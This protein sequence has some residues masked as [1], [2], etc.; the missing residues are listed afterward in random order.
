MLTHPVQELRR[1][2]I[3]YN[4]DGVN[5]RQVFTNS[6]SWTV[7][8]QKTPLLYTIRPIKSK[9]LR[10]RPTWQALPLNLSLSSLRDDHDLARLLAPAATSTAQPA[11]SSQTQDTKTQ[12]PVL[13]ADECI[14]IPQSLPESSAFSTSALVSSPTTS[15]NESSISLPQT[16]SIPPHS[17]THEDWTF[18]TTPSSSSQI[19][20]F[21]HPS[22][23]STPFSEPETWILLGDD[24]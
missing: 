1:L 24:L 21:T 2:G 9:R 17:L 12:P 20:Q 8:A 3:L 22:I 16:S 10:R 6:T 4:E 13:G 23:A 14:S 15:V 18:I 19:Q 7:P 11:V 5:T